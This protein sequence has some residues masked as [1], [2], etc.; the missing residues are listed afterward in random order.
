VPSDSSFGDK[1][2]VRALASSDDTGRLV[3][4]AFDPSVR[5]PGGFS[6]VRTVVD[7]VDSSI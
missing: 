7:A 3:R 1:R 2:R 6:S 5:G 4:F